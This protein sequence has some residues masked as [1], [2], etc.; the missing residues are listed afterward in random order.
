MIIAQAE[1]HRCFTEHDLLVVQA[2]IRQLQRFCVLA[3]QGGML[4]RLEPLP[5]RLVEVASSFLGSPIP[6]SVARCAFSY[7]RTSSRQA[8]RSQ[9]R[10]P[11][12]C[13]D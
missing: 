12:Q 7:W 5:E 6:D 10:Q 8:T 2:A 3:G 4:T 11:V 9:N 13:N 1:V